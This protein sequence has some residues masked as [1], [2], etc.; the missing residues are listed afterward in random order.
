MHL[1]KEDGTYGL[2]IWGFGNSEWS[3]RYNYNYTTGNETTVK[4]TDSVYICSNNRDTPFQFLVDWAKDGKSKVGFR[5]DC[6]C[7][8]TECNKNFHK[9]EKWPLGMKML[10]SLVH[11]ESGPES[12]E[13]GIRYWGCNLANDSEKKKK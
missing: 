7:H 10:K 1:T 6:F 2:E 5:L 11:C 3:Q 9:V 4:F 8:T 13:Y 12:F